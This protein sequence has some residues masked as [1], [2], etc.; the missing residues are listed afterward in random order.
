MDEEGMD[1]S[2]I[3]FILIV[4]VII[5]GVLMYY[6]DRKKYGASDNRAQNSETKMNDENIIDVQN[7]QDLEESDN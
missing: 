2:T 4:I 7:E 3:L 6:F 1:Y 5:V